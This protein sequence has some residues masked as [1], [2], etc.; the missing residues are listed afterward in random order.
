M[1]NTADRRNEAQQLNT[2]YEI[3]KVLSSS[4]DLSKT[5]REVLNILGIQMESR[6]GMISLM[7]ETG[8]LHL[9]GATGMS[10]EEFRRGRFRVG[11]GITGRIY[12]TGIPSVVADI[13][14]EPLF[15]NRT[16]EP[17]VA[18]GKTIAFIGVPIKAANETLGV[19]SIDR[20]MDSTL[21]S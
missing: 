2:I 4:L 5:L 9:V 15:L 20:I 18:G 13:S 12:Q 6:R 17:E 8:E 21:H 7:Q 11:E 3:S 14:N 10:G 1:T 19:L 16:A